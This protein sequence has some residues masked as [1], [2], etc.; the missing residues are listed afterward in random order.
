VVQIKVL[1]T[2]AVQDVLREFAPAFERARQ[3]SLVIDYDPA[4]ALKRRI[5]NGAAFD[6][7]IVT[8]PVIDAL[9]AQRRIVGESVTDIGR[10][11]LGIAVRKGVAKPDIST[12]DALKRALIAAKSVVRSREGTSGLYFESLLDRLGIAAA[13]RGKIV[14]GGSGRI[15]ELVA[16]GEA[17]LAVQQIPELLPVAGVDF[18]GPLPDELQ[19]Y[20]VFST[21]VSAAC[22]VTEAAEAFIN[23]LAAPSAAS[24]FEAKGLELIP[25]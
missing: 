4:N 16:R 21:G 6:V 14:L 25:H 19:L 22:A 7:A 24:L 8:R 18:A 5:E 10:S 12:A 3:V 11:G 15:A 17:E 20:T 23:D 2:H 1:S 9:V 13:M